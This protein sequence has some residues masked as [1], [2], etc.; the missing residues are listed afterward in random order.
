MPM[1][2]GESD[3]CL[4]KW[5][6]YGRVDAPYLWYRELK[7]VLISLGFIVCPFDGCL[8]VLVSEGSQGQPI[9]H[10]VMGVHV[11]DGIGGGDSHFKEVLQKL[12]KRFSFGAYSEHEFDFCG[13]HYRQWDDGTIELGQQEYLRKIEPLS[14]P[15][16]RRAEPNAELTDSERQCLRGLCG[17]LQFA[18]VH[19]RPDLCAKVGQLQASIPKGKVS[20]LLEGNRILYEGKQHPVCVLIVPIP[21]RD[22][23]FCAFSDASFATAK[24]LSSRQG[25]LMFSTSSQLSQN[26]KAVVCPMA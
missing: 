14:V 9:A 22:V 24:N 2:M 10:G 16:N 7:R 17:S 6:A 4:F 25:T 3:Q 12:K 5:G 19:S 20:D 8:F 13:V 11:D 15:K 23:T 26:Q 1:S 18:A 21:L